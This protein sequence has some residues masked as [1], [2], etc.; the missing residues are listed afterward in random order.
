M[1]ATSS[2]LP[3]NYSRIGFTISTNPE[4]LDVTSFDHDGTLNGGADANSNIFY[5]DGNARHGRA[6]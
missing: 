1:S 4:L 5:Y 2:T 6:N 3:V